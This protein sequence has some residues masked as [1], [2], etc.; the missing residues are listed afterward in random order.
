VPTRGAAEADVSALE[1]V[2]DAAASGAKRRKA[3]ASH[4]KRP[5]PSDLENPF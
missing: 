5:I 2:P 1:V 3:A 4:D